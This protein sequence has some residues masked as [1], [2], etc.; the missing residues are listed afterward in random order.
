MYGPL[1]GTFATLI[2]YGRYI[3]ILSFGV[4]LGFYFLIRVK[5]KL[6][7]HIFIILVLLLFAPIIAV[8]TYVI[9]VFLIFSA[10][11]I[12]I[13]ME[14]YFKYLNSHSK[15]YH[16]K[17]LSIFLISLLYS[18]IFQFWVPG[19]YDDTENY[20]TVY[21][22]E[23]DYQLGIYYKYNTNSSFLTEDT[24]IQGRVSAIAVTIR[25]DREADTGSYKLH[26]I[27]SEGFWKDG[28]YFSD[29]EYANLGEVDTIIMNSN[30]NSDFNAKYLLERYNLG[31]LIENNRAIDNQI[32]RKSFFESAANQTYKLYVNE[33]ATVTI[34]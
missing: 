29:S 3:G 11:L 16:A 30:Y 1:S 31:Y 12:S 9:W 2:K 21:M 15:N 4:I 23:A 6:R 25:V 26:P 10:I 13:A 33:K 34:V 7:K 28:W 22:E 32:Q 14:A 20:N 27:Y 24:A 5:S 8:G 19:F 18:A 17:L